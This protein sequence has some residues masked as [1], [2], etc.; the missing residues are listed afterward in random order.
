MDTPWANLIMSRCAPGE[1]SRLIAGNTVGGAAVGGKDP[2]L[3][4][5]ATGT[6]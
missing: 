4:G 5:R 6:G 2:A 3:P 1:G